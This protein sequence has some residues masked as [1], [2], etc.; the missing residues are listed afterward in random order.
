MLKDFQGTIRW[1]ERST[2]NSSLVIWSFLLV[3]ISIF[4]QMLFAILALGII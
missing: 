2:F 1:W 4:I 3:E